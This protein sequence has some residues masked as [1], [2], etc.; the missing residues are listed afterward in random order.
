[1]AVNNAGAASAKLTE[2]CPNSRPS[3]VTETFAGAADSVRQRH[4]AASEPKG[5][6]RVRGYNVNAIS[7]LEAWRFGVDDEAGKPLRAR[8]FAGSCEHDIVVRDSSVGNPGFDSI[9]AD[10]RRPIP[11]RFRRERTN[12]RPGLR[13]RERKRRDMM[14]VA[15]RR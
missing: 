8:P 6:K 12:V 11:G 10:M 7:N 9:D 15:H 4:T 13:L 5:C 14:T 3:R 1:M 2:V